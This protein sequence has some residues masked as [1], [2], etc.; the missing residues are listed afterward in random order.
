MIHVESTSTVIAGSLSMYIR[1]FEFGSSGT[2]PR[3]S[4]F[5]FGIDASG[6]GEYI[7]IW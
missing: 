3:M 5:S 4:I 1:A 2:F 6:N 7:S